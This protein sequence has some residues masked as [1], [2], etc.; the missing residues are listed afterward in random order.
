MTPSNFTVRSVQAF[1]Y[2]YKLSTPVITSF[3]RMMDRPA[4]FVRVQDEDGYVGWGEVWCNFPATGAE[5]RA[6]LVNE[7]LG[8]RVARNR[9]QRAVGVLRQAHR[10]ECQCWRYNRA[11][12]VRSRRPSPVSIWRS[13][14]FTRAGETAVVETPRRQRQHDQGLCQRYQPRRFQRDGRGGS[15]PWTSR[16]EIENRF[17]PN[18]DRANLTSLRGLVGKGMLAADVNQGWSLERA[19]EVAPSLVEFGLAWLE[20]PI[21]ADRPSDRMAGITHSRSAAAGGR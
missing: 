5:H 11:N 6:R 15:A 4:V 18:S 2:R 21:R 9:R 12:P 3:G 7:V 1:C 19:I 20:E 14:I 16:P 17:R 13:G 8:A 10:L